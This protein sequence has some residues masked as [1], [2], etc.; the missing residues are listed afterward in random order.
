MSGDGTNGR[1]TLVPEFLP[2]PGAGQ[3]IGPPERVAARARLLLERFRGVGATAGAAILSLQCSGYT[4]VDPL[5]PPPAQCTSEPTPFASIAAH[6]QYATRNVS[7]PQVLLTLYSQGYPNYA[8]YGITAVRVTGGSL[9]GI[10]DM[11]Q[12]GPGGSTSLVVTI[13]PVDATTTEILADVDLTCGAATDTK[14]YRISYHLPA[15]EYDSLTVTEITV[16]ADAGTD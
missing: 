15:N 5:P 14:H 16:A 8:G 7:P 2:A 4:V 6:A 11:S 13:A 9:I 12:S 3:P 10:E 1:K